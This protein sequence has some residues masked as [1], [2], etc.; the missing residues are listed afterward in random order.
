MLWRRFLVMTGGVSL[1]VKDPSSNRV[2][3]AV[4]VARANQVLHVQISETENLMRRRF[5][6]ATTFCDLPLLRHD[7]L[8]VLNEIVSWHRQ[9]FGRFGDDVFRTPRF[10]LF[11]VVFRRT[12]HSDQLD[13]VVESD[14]LQ[15][16]GR[17]VLLRIK[18][19]RLFQQRRMRQCGR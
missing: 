16:S 12:R 5:I 17:T 9:L 7:A 8:E 6:A 14:S 4:L 11:L 2:V 3:P 18:S 15:R 19:A 10:V 13:V 1:T